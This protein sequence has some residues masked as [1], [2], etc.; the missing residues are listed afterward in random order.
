[1]TKE[2][3]TTEILAKEVFIEKISIVFIII[4]GIFLLYK[5]ITSFNHI[6]YAI[7]FLAYIVSYIVFR[8]IG[9]SFVK[10]FLVYAAVFLMDAILRIIGKILD[11]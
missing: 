9:T 10:I 4:I 6:E 11:K 3:L 5:T 1:M 8:T 7:L 2:I